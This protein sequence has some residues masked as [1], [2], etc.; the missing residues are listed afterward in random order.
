MLFV[1]RCLVF[2]CL[3][4]LSLVSA[5]HAGDGLQVGVAETD[6]TPPVGFPMAGYYHE[7]L[8]EGK[9]DPLQAK[10][11]VFREGNTA[12]ALVV[13]D[14]IGVATDLSKEVRRLAAE[15]TGI[16]AENIVL[17]ATHSHTAPDYMKELYLYLG[18]EKQQPPINPEIPRISPRLSVK[19]TS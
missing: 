6:I 8:A 12:G 10:A 3:C 15:K 19:L 4:L 16:P 17:A 11:I 14:L 5:A 2:C 13:C 18:K 7:R 9:I 1:S